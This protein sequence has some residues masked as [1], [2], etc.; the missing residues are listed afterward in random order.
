MPAT[1]PK[2]WDPETRTIISFLRRHIAQ[3][4]RVLDIGCGY[5]R[6]LVALRANGFDALGVEINQTI[7]DKNRENGLPCISP[8]ELKNKKEKFDAILL[9]HVV[10]HFG[11]GD[12]LRFLN[13]QFNFLK[14]EGIV[15]IATP[16]MN[17][18]FFD[19]FDHVRPYHPESL[20][21]VYGRSGTSQMQ[22]HGDFG[23]ELLDLW[24]RKSAPRLSFSRG[25]HVPGL[26]RKVFAIVNRLLAALHWASCGIFSFTD[27]WVG[28]FQCSPKSS[29][30]FK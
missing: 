13:E 16:L 25:R 18:N 4:G 15:V 1:P 6:N 14:T 23:L 5:G 10:E 19:D 26:S 27:G 21:L 3:N 22:Y 11:P 17:P 29:S 8:S 7:V 2:R 9:S 30:T 28:V 24:Y 12:L 20:L